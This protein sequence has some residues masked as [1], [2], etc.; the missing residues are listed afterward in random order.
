MNRI[1]SGMN[2]VLQS[3]ANTLAGELLR[4]AHAVGGSQMGSVWFFEPSNNVFLASDLFAQLAQSDTHIHFF[5]ISINRDA[6]GVAG[7]M[8]VH[9]LGKVLLVIDLFP[10][11]R[12]NDVATQHDWHVPE[13]RA[14]GASA[15]P[16]AIGRA[17]L[18]RLHDQQSVIDG[19]THLV[20]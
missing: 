9:Y 8:I 2:E 12:D 16:G 3:E 19:K 1:A 17:A 20:R 5:L 14:L 13:I 10:V 15:K 4:L 11:D 18:N 6:D 7:A